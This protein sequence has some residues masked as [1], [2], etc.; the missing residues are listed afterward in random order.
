MTIVRLTAYLG[1]A[2]AAAAFQAR[3]DESNYWPA[4]VKRDNH[5]GQEQSWSAA[6]PFLF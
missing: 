2:G 4:Y 1:L 3:A 6:G 5:S